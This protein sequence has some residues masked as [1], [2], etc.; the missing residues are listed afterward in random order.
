MSLTVDVLAYGPMVTRLNIKFGKTFFVSRSKYKIP[1]VNNLKGN[2][3]IFEF[4]IY[5]RSINSVAFFF[6]KWTTFFCESVEGVLGHPTEC[7]MHVSVELISSPNTRYSVRSTY[8]A[9]FHGS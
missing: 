6:T 2:S 9:C 1:E 4:V 8:R 7:P 5:V 3:A